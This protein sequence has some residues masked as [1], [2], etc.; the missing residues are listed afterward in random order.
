MSKSTKTI[1]TV[2]NHPNIKLLLIE[3]KDHPFG[4]NYN[5]QIWKNGLYAGH[6]KFFKTKKDAL[7]YIKDSNNF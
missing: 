2:K 1:F 7:T 3:T 4:Y 5:V 6:G